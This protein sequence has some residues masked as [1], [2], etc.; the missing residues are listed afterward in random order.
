VVNQVHEDGRT[1]EREDG[2]AASPDTP[3]LSSSRSPV[4]G[5]ALL[6]WLQDRDARGLAAL[7]QL[8]PEGPPVAALPLLPEPPTGLAALEAF[9]RMALAGFGS[10]GQPAPG[11]RWR[12]RVTA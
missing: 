9:G 10:G 2:R 8:V 11:R 1:G 6:T 5:P 7:R 12:R 3:L 4:D